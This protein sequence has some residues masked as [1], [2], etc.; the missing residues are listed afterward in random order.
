MSNLANLLN[1]A[2][3]SDASS[4]AHATHH[5]ETRQHNRNIS[6]TSP[7]EALAIAA[8][9]SSPVLSPN[10]PITA[11]MMP[12]SAHQRTYSGSSS[13]PDS[14]HISL[15]MP[16]ALAHPSPS[17][18]P[19]FD[20]HAP[21]NNQMSNRKLSDIS[22]E[23]P[24]Q[25]PPLRSSLSGET[26]ISTKAPLHE[27]PLTQVHDQ[28]TSTS[29][30]HLP[31]FRHIHDAAMELSSLST[32][33]GIARSQSVAMTPQNVAENNVDQAQHEIKP[34]IKEENRNSVQKTSDTLPFS[35][36]QVDGPNDQVATEASIS[37]LPVVAS[38]KREDSMS[39]FQPDAEVAVP[40]NENSSTPQP[41]AAKKRPAPKEKKI[42]KKGIASAIKKPTVKKR[43]LDLD[44]VDGTPISQRSGT[45]ASSRASK[46]PAPRNRK[47]GSATPMQSS[48]A[49]MSRDVDTN[50]DDDV[51]DD[52]DSELFCICRKPD[53]HTWMIG[54]DGGCEDWFHGRCV[55]MNERD[56]NLI[57]KYICPNCKENGIGQT[58]WKPMCR[59]DTCREPARV[60]GP[61]P[62]KYC[63]DQH[64]E[65][66]MA[67]RA[68]GKDAKKS[69]GT[70]GAGATGIGRRR[71]KDNITDNQENEDD[72]KNE[73]DGEDDQ[74]YLRGGILH[75]GELKALT[76]GVKD[77]EE[78]NKL[79]EGVLSPPRTASPDEND[80]EVDD[81]DQ[82]S[83]EK[84]KVVYTTE[85]KAQLANIASK[86]TS[87]KRK[88]EALDVREKFLGLVRGRAKSTLEEL[89]KKEGVK[90]I[91]GFDSRLTWSEEEFEHWRTSSGGQKSLESG[92][93]AAPNTVPD[94]E[95][96]QKMTNGDSSHAEEIGRGVCQKKRCER[97]KQWFKLQQQEIAF[98]KDEC[99]QEMRK[100]ESEE[101]GVGERAMIRHLE[102]G[103]DQEP[104]GMGALPS[105]ETMR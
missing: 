27:G 48:P 96:D 37:P 22:N 85:E 24:R 98:E 53:D 95:G 94:E 43:K 103:N 72:E 71:R 15:P 2:P 54:C 84:L 51:D 45:P 25:L 30:Q 7:L 62:S 35:H 80:M 36:L 68:L 69:E 67:M 40:E 29:E 4:S 61:K 88:R 91:C 77:L 21:N 50:D 76:S 52:D 18:S 83:K 44:S 70:K 101:K 104:E 90:D 42:E 66:F 38:M 41:V 86:K 23:A 60:T 100:L 105:D 26:D 47:Q 16:H 57:D 73:N 11:P 58:T 9:T 49:P 13:R 31:S 82:M 5:G 78:F 10:H 46:T 65:Q 74:A 93:L 75:A 28:Q 79:G 59:L 33:S 32:T 8:T 6:L 56:G 1:P 81:G 20:H 55:N 92:V 63:C 19:T 17:F 14:S 39:V 64:G 34:E 89:K 97:H 99:R 12:S 87:L 3:N 102:G